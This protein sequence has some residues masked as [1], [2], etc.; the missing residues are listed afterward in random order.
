MV[1]RDGCT[2]PR[3]RVWGVGQI[4]PCLKGVEREEIIRIIAKQ[5]G[6]TG[7][8]TE[9]EEDV[10]MGR[11][12]DGGGILSETSST[13]RRNQAVEVEVRDGFTQQK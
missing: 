11:G 9:A 5:L 13:S 3:G 12:E 2:C 1:H 4:P 8:A 6:S 10:D 7:W